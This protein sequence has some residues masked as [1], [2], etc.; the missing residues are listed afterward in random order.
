MVEIQSKCGLWFSSCDLNNL[1]NNL[2]EKTGPERVH[3][4]GAG[5]HEFKESGLCRI[6]PSISNKQIATGGEWRA[7]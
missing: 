6:W 1:E 7:I 2:S 3:T 5:R 4:S